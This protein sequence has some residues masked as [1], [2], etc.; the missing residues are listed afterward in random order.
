MYKKAAAV[1]LALIL[2]AAVFSGC[3]GGKEAAEEPTKAV[4]A[5]PVKTTE[6][7]TEKTSE[8][9]PEET[10][11]AELGPYPGELTSILLM[12]AH[13]GDF[14]DEN[15]EI[16]ALTHILITI[17]PETRSLRFTTFPY[18][19]MVKPYMQ[20]GEDIKECQ[21]QFLYK[22]YGGDVAA[23]TI[24]A[25]FGVKIDGWVV[26]NMQG[27]KDIVDEVGGLE[28]NITDLSVNDIAEDLEYLTG[29]IWQEIKKTGRQILN[30]VQISGYFF[31][32]YRDLDEEDP[33]KAE[34]MK[35]REKHSSIIDAL[36]TA[37]KV[38]DPDE[39]QAVEIARKIDGS[40]I[41]NIKER[42]WEKIAKMA[43]ACA[44]N[45]PEFLH[46]PQEI[47]AG[48]DGWSMVYDEVKDINTVMKFVNGEYK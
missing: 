6:T 10:P 42:D 28:M 13:S 39:K 36:I 40:F 43:L 32:T 48:R 30:G 26:M 31:D 3:A 41:T 27:V 33:M 19:L 2:S 46:V 44:E 23:D 35:F 17:D 38:L 20:S 9:T 15:N 7:A 25:R 1:L 34:E 18:N 29:F 21:L 8:K 12:G 47:E 14:S 16:Y 45:E 22:N 37:V 24:S 11:E 5:E 4:T